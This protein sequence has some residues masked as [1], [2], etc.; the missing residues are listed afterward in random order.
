MIKK[1]IDK[2]EIN[3]NIFFYGIRKPDLVI[4]KKKIIISGFVGLYKIILLN[5]LYPIIY[6]RSR[7]EFTIEISIVD[8]V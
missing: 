6:S 8:F 5:K 4:I 3:K 2:I 7:Q 1:R